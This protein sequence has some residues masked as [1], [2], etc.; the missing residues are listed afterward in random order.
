MLKQTVLSLPMPEVEV[1]NGGLEILKTADLREPLASL[2]VPHLRIYGYLDGLVRARW[3]RCWMRCGRRVNQW[4][5]P[6]RHMRRSS[7][8]LLSFVRR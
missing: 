4:W 5:L 8:I 2:T 1:L 7:L 3:F 6:K